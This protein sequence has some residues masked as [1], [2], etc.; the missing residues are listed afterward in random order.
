VQDGVS[1]FVCN[2]DP[3]SVAQ[4]LRRTMDDRA[5]AERMG[6]GA[7]EFAQRLSWTDAVKRL[8]SID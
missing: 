7:H 8:T 4:A 3:P 5:L 1:G 2:P 6:S